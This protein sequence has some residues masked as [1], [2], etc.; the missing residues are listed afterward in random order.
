MYRIL[1]FKTQNTMKTL[2]VLEELGVE[3]DF[4]YVDLY[5]GENRQES[6][7]KIAPMGKVP[8]LQHDDEGIFESGAICRYVANIENSELYP[9]DKLQ[10]AKVDQWMDFFSCHLGRQIN[11]IC[12]EKVIKKEANMGSAN[13]LAC[14]EALKFANKQLIS[15]DRWLGESKFLAGEKI[16]IADLCAFAY[17]EQTSKINFSLDEY[18]N[19]K[20]WLAEI[21]KL[22]SIRRARQRVNP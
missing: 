12:F 18:S 15:I 22:P 9:A 6:F 20:K 10:R 14:E 16:S 11:I 5:K 21:E 8:A 2:Y 3:Y 13:E 4:K 19:V 7:L 1:G 17:L